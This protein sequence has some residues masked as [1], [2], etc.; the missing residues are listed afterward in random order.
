[1]PSVITLTDFPSNEINDV[2]AMSLRNDFYFSCIWSFLKRSYP[3]QQLARMRNMGYSEEYIKKEFVK[4]DKTKDFGWVCNKLMVDDKL[5]GFTIW[6]YPKE[7]TK[8]MLE[9][10]FVDPTHRG[11]GF[12]N[13]LVSHFK[14]QAI[15]LEKSLCKIQVDWNNE[16][17]QQFY[18]DW[19]WEHGEPETDNLPPGL[20]EMYCVLP[21]LDKIHDGTANDDTIRMM[22]QVGVQV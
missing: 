9:F 18:K 22:K 3:P 4:R 2:V 13:I 17:L 8:C 5:A 12:G 19:G 10:V 7:G 1:M 14:I 16:R 11:N 21:P 20:V 6:D 15:H